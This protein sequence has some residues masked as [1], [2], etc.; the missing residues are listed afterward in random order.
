MEA[1][2]ENVRRAAATIQIKKT[3]AKVT[4]SSRRT[5][6]PT[7]RFEAFDNHRNRTPIEETTNEFTGFWTLKVDVLNFRKTYDNNTSAMV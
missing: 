3:P 7:R 6:T 5:P 4:S 2:A 1:G